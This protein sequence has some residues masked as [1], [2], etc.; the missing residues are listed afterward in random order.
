MI[1]DD[2]NE[3]K[4]SQIGENM[5]RMTPGTLLKEIVEK[6]FL[7]IHSQATCQKGYK[8]YIYFLQIRLNEPVFT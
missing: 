4:Q 6:G 1:I 5:H 8:T 2:E 7:E 3:I